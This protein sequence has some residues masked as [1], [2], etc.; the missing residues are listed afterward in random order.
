MVDSPEKADKEI[1]FELSR[2]YFPAELK[3]LEKI[4]KELN[5]SSLEFRK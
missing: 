5:L 4:K 2:D 3:Y 1:Y